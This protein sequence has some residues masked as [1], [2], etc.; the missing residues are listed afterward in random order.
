MNC[1]LLKVLLLLG[2]I[3]AATARQR[4]MGHLKVQQQDGSSFSKRDSSSDSSSDDTNPN[5]VEWAAEVGSQQTFADLSYVHVK[6]IVP[7]FPANRSSGSDFLFQSTVQSVQ[8]D[9][10]LWY[11][12]YGGNVDFETDPN[13]PDWSIVS[14]ISYAANMTLPYVQ[15]PTIPVNVG[16][17]IEGTIERNDNL[18][19]TLSVNGVQQSVISAPS[20]ALSGNFLWTGLG[21]WSWQM[22]NCNNLPASGKIEVTDIVIKDNG[23]LITPSWSYGYNTNPCAISIVAD[24]TDAEFSWDTASWTGSYTTCQIY[25]YVTLENEWVENGVTKY[26]WN[27]HINSWWVDPLVNYK[28]ALSSP[29]I[30]IWGV[31]DNGDGTYSLPDYALP[32]TEE[33]GYAFGLI[34]DKPVYVI[35]VDCSAGK[36][37][38]AGIRVPSPSFAPINLGSPSNS[39]PQG[40]TSQITQSI[41]NTWQTNGVNYVQVNAVLTNNGSRQIT[42]LSLSAGAQASSIVTSWSVTQDN[43]GDFH[44]PSWLASL[45]PA[46]TLQFGYIA[47][48]STVLDFTTQLTCY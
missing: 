36:F 15:S 23:T 12:N 48:S 39:N 38:P 14:Q 28:F 22:E 21:F 24:S 25:S 8:G 32:L 37:Y 47:Q 44:L 17:V 41:A 35:N 2:L 11:L 18:I 3:A 46:Q 7:P 42:A 30:Q 9:A 29:A 19:I 20:Y 6:L 34:T 16:D 1:K 33:G 4:P 26:Q 13:F 40:C 43:S 10:L 45:N 27:Y 31:V 5:D